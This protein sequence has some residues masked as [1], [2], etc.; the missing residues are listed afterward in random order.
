METKVKLQLMGLG[1]VSAVKPLS[2]E[3]AVELAADMLGEMVV[4]G[5]ACGCLLF[6]YKRQERKV[7]GKEDVQNTRL[8]QLEAN[9]SSIALDIEEQN[10]RLRDIQRSL[11]G[12][13]KIPD[14]FRRSLLPPDDLPDQLVDTKISTVLQVNKQ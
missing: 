6:E 1:K 7:A 8:K 2:D 13:R 12:G 5:V 14:S 11:A 9:I 4:F 3:I 10:A